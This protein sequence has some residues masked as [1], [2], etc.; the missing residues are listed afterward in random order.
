M[1][2]SFGLL[3]L[4]VVCILVIARL[5]KDAKA[6]TRYMTYLAIS[7]LVGAGVKQVVVANTISSPE[8]TIVISTDSIPTHIDSTSVVEKVESPFTEYAGKE[9]KLECDTVVMKTRKASTLRTE[10]GYID[11]S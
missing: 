11:D 2:N 1:A 10:K 5:L 8:Q 9:E 3:C 4:A 7:L 6:F